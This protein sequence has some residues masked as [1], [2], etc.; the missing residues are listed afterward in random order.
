M[1]IYCCITDFGQLGQLVQLVIGHATLVMPTSAARDLAEALAKRR[2]K[3]L[4]SATTAWE[5]TYCGHQSIDVISHQDHVAL[6][7]GAANLRISHHEKREIRRRILAAIT[8]QHGFRVDAPIIGESAPAP[9][10]QPAPESSVSSR[11]CE[12]PESPAHPPS[13]APAGSSEAR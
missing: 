11:R 4:R 2:S 1:N 12:A 10:P 7:T 13:H 3:H 6:I 9:A 5:S 8:N